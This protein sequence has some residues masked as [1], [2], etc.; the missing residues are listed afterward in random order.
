M[1]TDSTQS[2][3][4]S[5]HCA[6]L[7]AQL[8]HIRG[9]PNYVSL[10]RSLHDTN[11][12]VTQLWDIFALGVPLC[13]LFD[14]LPEDAGF[15]K[16][17]HSE[18]D[19]EQYDTDPDRA[20]KHAI[21]LFAIQIRT[22]NVTDKIPDCEAFT[23]ADLWDRGSTDGFGKAVATVTAIVNHLPQD[24]FITGPLEQLPPHVPLFNEAQETRRNNVIRELVETERKYLG[25]LEHMQNYAVVV[26]QSNLIDREMHDK[27]FAN[28]S[29]LVKFHRKFLVSVNA[30]AGLAWEDQ[31]W[32]LLFLEAEK[33]FGEIYVPYCANYTNIKFTPEQERNLSSLNHLMNLKGELPAFTIKPIGRVCKYPLLLECLI[34]TSSAANYQHYE[35]LK[36]GLQAHRRVTDLINEAQRRA[37]NERT[38][39]SL[40]TRIDDWK[41]HNLKDFGDL[42]LDDIFEVVRAGVRREYHV[43]LFERI[44]LF[45][46]E[47]AS[48]HSYNRRSGNSPLLNKGRVFL[49][50]IT[51]AVSNAEVEV[52]ASARHFLLTVHWKG[53]NGPESFVLRLRREDQMKQWEKQINRLIQLPVKPSES[54]GTLVSD[55]DLDGPVP[56]PSATTP[57]Q[58]IVH[59]DAPP[60]V[61]GAIPTSVKVKAHFNEDIFVFRVSPATEYKVLIEKIQRKLRLCTSA[62][63]GDG[64]LQLKYQDVNGDMVL[65]GSSADLRIALEECRE[66]LVLYVM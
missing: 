41:G 63:P 48:A 34:K 59:N 56:S 33:E 55:S 17:N 66:L 25:D 10:A 65:L 50:D 8:M 54:D 21:A 1:Q 49:S 36:R 26:A 9:F 3:S 45:C 15:N 31:R 14:L 58:D 38:V 2:T 18:F 16:I 64:P 28:T 23:V 5:G 57:L 30:N 52:M 39:K 12:P 44:L 4:L 11:D 29:E 40:R 46:K 27:I 60:E 6:N 24:V 61:A 51:Q 13:Y 53:A 42:V 20:K 7:L 35:E 62:P 32:G 19:E 47:V 37:E 22:D 43:F